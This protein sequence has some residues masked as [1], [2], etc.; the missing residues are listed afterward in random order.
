MRIT[1]I[2]ASQIPSRTANSMEVMK[3]CQAFVELGHSVRLWVPGRDP[4]EERQLLKSNYG[5]RVEFPI[6]WM[7]ASPLL[8]R[9]DFSF[10]A[11]RQAQRWGAELYYCWPLQAAAYSSMRNLPTVVEMHDLPKGRLGPR[12]LR[13]ALKGSGLKQVMPITRALKTCLS[14][15]YG[16]L[17]DEVGSVV[18][19]SGVDLWQ[20]ENLPGP[21]EA[22][23]E[24]GLRDS[25]TAGYTGHLYEGRGMNMLL[26]LAERCPEI[27]FIW[28][29]GE[30]ETVA[31]WK[32]RIAAQGLGNIILLGFVENRRLPMVQ[33]A[34][35]ALL[36]PYERRISVSSG[37][38]TARFASPMKLFEYLASGRAIL[39]SDLPVFREVLNESNSI[40]LPP[41]DVVAWSSA[42][43]DLMRDETRR[44]QLARQARADAS[45]YDWR[46]RQETVLNA[47]GASH[48][49]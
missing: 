24:L 7:P 10:H 9:Y 34:C 13:R 48:A 36:M 25:I 2:A 11:V 28:A 33:A 6:T 43:K 49:V 47:L 8:R 16:A 12:L 26:E 35:E 5:L 32:D 4:A 37:G 38:D 23:A 42:L 29:G 39:S 14:G 45:M 40:L 31:Q 1:C 22:R 18:L 3:V 41:E 27:Q 19:P 21:A 30:R 46:A 15:E 44:R 20:Y 17:F